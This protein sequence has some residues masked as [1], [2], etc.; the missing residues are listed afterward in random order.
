LLAAF[1]CFFFVRRDI[2]PAR[3]LGRD[4]ICFEWVPSLPPLI[5]RTVFP[6]FVFSPL[7]FFVGWRFGFQGFPTL[8][9][10]RINMCQLR[11][12]PFSLCCLFW[13]WLACRAFLIFRRFFFEYVFLFSLPPYPPPPMSYKEVPSA[14]GG[15]PSFSP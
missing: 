2:L 6:A 10:S 1:S 15:R 14:R 7:A 12:S 9:C 13:S 11:V 5:F 3:L 8:F 4:R